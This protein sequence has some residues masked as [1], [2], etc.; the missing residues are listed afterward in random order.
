MNFPNVRGY[1]S[2]TQEKSTPNTR[3]DLAPQSYSTSYTCNTPPRLKKYTRQ[4]E[5]VQN[6]GW[7]KASC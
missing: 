2:V 1:A 3:D 5:R 4:Q 7:A 6:V